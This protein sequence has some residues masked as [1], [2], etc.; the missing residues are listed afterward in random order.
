[1]NNKSLW[2]KIQYYRNKYRNTPNGWAVAH[3]IGEEYDNEK[4][5]VS[6][7]K[8]EQLVKHKEKAT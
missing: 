3:L 7:K 6:K 1:M 2:E 8:R 5:R 4:S